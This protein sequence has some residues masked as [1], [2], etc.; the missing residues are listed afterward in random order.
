M[1]VRIIVLYMII[2]SFLFSC[3]GDEHLQMIPA[4]GEIESEV[5]YNSESVIQPY[6]TN[7]FYWEYHGS[8]KLLIGGSEDDNIFQW[9]LD[10][11]VEHLDLLQSSGGNYVR[12]VLNHARNNI[13]GFDRNDVMPH[14]KRDGLYDLD[15]FNQE[16]FDRLERFLMEAWQRDIIVQLTFWEA[17]DFLEG[18]LEGK[19]GDFYAR[20]D[21]LSWNPKNN[22]NYSADDSGMKESNTT[23][24]TW[25]KEWENQVGFFYTVPGMS[26][27]N[28][29]LRGYQEKF[30]RRVLD[31]TLK[32]DNVLYNVQNERQWVIP[33][34]WPDYWITFA[35]EYAESQGK[36]IYVT[37]MADKYYMNQLQQQEAL[38]S[39]NTDFFEISQVN[40]L[41]GQTQYDEIINA[42][43]QLSSNKKPINAIKIYRPSKKA[44][45][46]GSFDDED[47][48]WRLI[49]GG[50]AAVRFHRSTLPSADVESYGFGLTSESQ[51]QIK[52]ARMFADEV[53]LF[54]MKPDNSKL[55]QRTM[56]E[57]YLLENSGQEYAIYF[58]GVDDASVVLELS[59]AKEMIQLD[60]LDIR[61]QQWIGSGS[62]FV[63]GRTVT[64]TAPENSQYVAVLR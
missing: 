32:F 25:K 35:R 8:P 48:M 18:N 3:F 44:Q 54:A 59:E 33:Q 58:T 64:V 2:G 50:A 5:K 11:L 16:Y 23:V 31:S 13:S 63:D 53:N 40:H 51:Q 36:I 42:R 38:N 41:G 6:K 62:V 15:D 39:K 45:S 37:D 60:W 55:S 47:K 19:L 49:F 1:S 24:A 27:D 12:N 22:I 28:A 52:S 56:N 14:N 29:L 26:N 30:I 10:E 7:S 4:S 46:K 34:T 57:A 17:W 21:Q 20:Y 9:P 61:T 43:N